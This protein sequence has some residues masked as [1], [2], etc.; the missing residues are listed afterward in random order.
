MKRP[1]KHIHRGHRPARP[2][3]VAL[4]L[5]AMSWEIKSN[6]EVLAAVAAVAVLGLSLWETVVAPWMRRRNLKHPCNAYF[7]IREL[8]KGALDYAIQDDKAHN[9]KELVLPSNSIV[10]IEVAYYPTI[11]FHVDETVFECEG[12]IE[13]KPIVESA[14]APF[15][16]KGNFPAVTEY[17]N[18]HGGYHYSSRYSGRAVNSC[19]T[20]GFKLQTKKPG[21]YK[22]WIGFLTDQI[23]GDAKDLTIRV[24]DNPSTRMKCTIHWGCK[25]RPYRLVS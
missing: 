21:V 5:V 6:W 19:Y 12:D 8:N 14:I 18:R 15:V 22:A 4:A 1:P 3:A 23:D 25:I 24:E 11:A 9:V 10:E 7:H 17:W 20:K 2:G 13:S 16:L